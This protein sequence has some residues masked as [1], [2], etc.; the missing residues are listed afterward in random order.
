MSGGKSWLDQK[1]SGVAEVR[2]AGVPGGVRRYS[3]EP[4]SPGLPL[5]LGQTPGSPETWLKV[6]H[7]ALMA[8]RTQSEQPNPQSLPPKEGAPGRS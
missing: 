6:M 3:A 7:S 8:L 1:R 5:C 2:G 4:G